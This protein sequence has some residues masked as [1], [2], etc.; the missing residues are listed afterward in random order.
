MT[1]A[2]PNILPGDWPADAAEPRALAEPIARTERIASIDTLRG[3][4]VLG[5]LPMNVLTGFALVAA[6][7]MNP[8]VAGGFEGANFYVWLTTH[9]VLDMKMMTIFS[10]LFG[11]GMIVLTDRAQSRGASS[12][13]IY[14][15][16]TAWLALI[17]F[18]HAW[19]LWFGDILFPYA[20]CGLL[21]YPT[22]K[23]RP[24]LLIAIGAALVFIG[25]AISF[26]MGAMFSLW[27]QGDPDGFAAAWADMRAGFD[28]TPAQIAEEVNARGSSV[29]GLMIFN[30][31]TTAQMQLFLLPLMMGWRILGAMLI[32]AGLMKLGV[33]SAERST[34]TYTAMAVLGYVI[35]FALIIP[36]ASASLDNPGDAAHI[37]MW[38]MNANYFGS[39]FVALGHVAVIML[40]CKSGVVPGVRRAL[41][42]VGQM[43]LTNYLTQTLICMF[44]FSAWG[45]GLF[46][47]LDRVQLMLVVLAIWAVQ[48]V[49]SSLWL[50][51]FRFGPAEWVW[52]S[53]TYW[54]AQPMRLSPV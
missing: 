23:L 46:N 35:G 39:L 34:A 28:P 40:V 36:G 47:K 45:L 41:A 51:R 27:Q 32:G 31:M 52:R 16:R 25:G 4:A 3:V 7:F 17:G 29:K 42:R 54:K 8:A 11:A 24:G 5:I 53:L 50:A 2:P 20:L 30:A 9:L 26:G 6:A 38:G 12:A 21:L 10:M 1:Q 15:R 19:V 13:A 43:A 44:L 14:Y 48:I 22:R 18:L 49:W 37:F 33:F